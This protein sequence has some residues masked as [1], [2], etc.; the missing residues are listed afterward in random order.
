MNM[1]KHAVLRY[2][3]F[4]LPFSATLPAHADAPLSVE[5]VQANCRPAVTAENYLTWFPLRIGGQD[6]AALVYVLRVRSL[7]ADDLTV[8]ARV[9]TYDTGKR[10][11]SGDESALAELK[12]GGS[13]DLPVRLLPPKEAGKQSAEIV[14]EYQK[15]GRLGAVS[16]L[17]WEFGTSTRVRYE[18]VDAGQPVVRPPNKMSLG[19]IR[20]ARP[21]YTPSKAE[22]ALLVVDAIGSI[23]G[24][25]TVVELLSQFASPAAR[26]V[27][28]KLEPSLL[29][30]S[31][32]MKRPKLETEGGQKRL[33]LQVYVREVETG[34]PQHQP[35][36]AGA[37]DRIVFV[38]HL[39]DGVKVA[40]QSGWMLADYAGAHAAIGIIDGV[41]KQIGRPLRV[42]PDQQL[43]E[44]RVS[45]RFD[46]SS[47]QRG[48]TIRAMAM[49]LIGPFGRMATDEQLAE[50]AIW[51]QLPP[52]LD[53]CDRLGDAAWI[54]DYEQWQRSPERAVWYALST[55]FVEVHG[56]PSTPNKNRSDADHSHSL[57]GE[58]TGTMLITEST[59]PRDEWTQD[60]FPCRVI[61]TQTGATLQGTIASGKQGPAYP[62]TGTVAGATIRWTEKANEGQG[63][64]GMTCNVQAR[65]QGD[66]IVGT[67][68][69]HYNY[70]GARYSGTIRI[71]RN[72]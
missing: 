53:A 6:T 16:P 1:T 66:A 22:V 64:W 12:A 24:L 39:P 63:Q 23:P 19:S 10:T 60:P 14:V 31:L 43:S 13:A 11:H 34:M 28:A 47:A 67:F 46:D 55:D 41:G 21:P 70:R 32:V 58:W 54:Y 37:F 35:T 68:E 71:E 69:Q 15:R 26:T 9:K 56:T 38:V 42:S 61:L 5:A 51:P 72:E 29:A 52:R 27:Q 57:T 45:L 25:G 33:T 7:T 65:L 50:V 48:Y 62:L 4:A 2:M 36:Y 17:A 40:P 30:D 8:R 49:A 18:V 20:A 3:L 44:P 59:Q